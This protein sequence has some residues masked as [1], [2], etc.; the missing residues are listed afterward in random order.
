MPV[1]G[2][3]KIIGAIGH[4]EVATAQTSLTQVNFKTGL[5]AS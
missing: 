1:V 5:A 3:L 4:F 2:H